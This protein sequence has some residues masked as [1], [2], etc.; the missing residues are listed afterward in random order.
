MF[1]EID[2][3]LVFTLSFGAGTHTFLAH[4]GWVGNVEDWLATLAIMSQQWHT[5]VYD[6]R[7]AGETSVPVEAIS[8]EALRDDIFRVMDA[9]GIERCVLGGFSAGTAAVLRAVLQHPERFEGLVLMNGAAGVPLPGTQLPTAPTSS[10]S[11]PSR[12]WPGSNY[13]ERLRWFIEQCTPEPDVEHIRRWGHHILLRAEP[14]AADRLWEVRFAEDIDFAARLPQLEIPTLIIHGEL[15]VFADRAR[16]EYLASLIPGSK[17]VVMEGSGHVPAMTRPADV[18]AAI[19][20]FFA[21]PIK[22]S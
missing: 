12:S 2:G 4:S 7:G 3:H 16:M 21:S 5:V 15:D 6:H 19:N 17:F 22:S 20:S 14:E 13:S 18:A 9:L 1:V 8:A 10:E 11:L